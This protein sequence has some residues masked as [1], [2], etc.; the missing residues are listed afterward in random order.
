MLGE[1]RKS[2]RWDYFRKNH[3]EI[4]DLVLLEIRIVY[5]AVAFGVVIAIYNLVI[6]VV[7]FV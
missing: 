6:V 1:E 2:I 7:D 4:N 3:Y 5:I